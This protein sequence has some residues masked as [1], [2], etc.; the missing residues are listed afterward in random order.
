MA[1]SE[2]KLAGTTDDQPDAFRLE[3]RAEGRHFVSG[4]V[5]GLVG[6][7]DQ[8]QSNRQITSLQLLNMSHTGLGAMSQEP[9]ETGRLVTIFLPPH[10]PEHGV[11]LTGRVVRCE[12][13]GYGYEIGVRLSN[14]MA[15]A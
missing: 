7:A 3:R 1:K 11:D 9:I 10:G 8:Y 5:T 14:K 2:L 13:K 12:R 15:A 6:M 4:R